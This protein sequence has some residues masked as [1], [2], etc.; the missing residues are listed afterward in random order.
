MYVMGWFQLCLPK[1]VRLLKRQCLRDRLA[2]TSVKLPRRSEQ[3]KIIKRSLERSRVF[4]WVFLPTVAPEIPR[5]PPKTNRPD[6]LRKEFTFLEQ[7]VRPACRV[8]QRQMQAS[9]S[10]PTADRGIP[11]PRAHNPAP[12]AE[13]KWTL[14][15][16]DRGI[17]RR[18]HTTLRLRQGLDVS[19]ACWRGVIHARG[20]QSCAFDED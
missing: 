7:Q 5:F 8:L 15:F 1:A 16:A 2:L 3:R 12:S 20:A 4:K 9:A 6:P 18:R 13:I 11:P 10:S 14:P 19:K 17:P